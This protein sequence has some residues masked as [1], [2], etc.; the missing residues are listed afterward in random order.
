M[1]SDAFFLLFNIHFLKGPSS[2][3][4]S[5]PSKVAEYRRRV[6]KSHSSVDLIDL[7][8]VAELRRKAEGSRFIKRDH[9]L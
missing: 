2:L 4:E 1:L 9:F 5:D 7:I 8:N 6:G 3:G